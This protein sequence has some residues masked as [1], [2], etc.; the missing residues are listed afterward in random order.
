MTERPAR[1]QLRAVAGHAEQANSAV[2]L[3]PRD[4]L[5]LLDQLDQAE[6]AQDEAWEKCAAMA[7]YHGAYDGSR[8][9]WLSSINPYTTT[10]KE[11]A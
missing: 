8:T 1:D 3:A 10:E 9:R 4:L 6:A 11:N 7:A 5:T 2:Y